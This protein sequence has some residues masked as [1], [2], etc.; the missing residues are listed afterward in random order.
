MTQNSA[1]ADDELLHRPR[2][3]FSEQEVVE[4]TM[5]AAL[6]NMTDRLNETFAT[7]LE[8]PVPGAVPVIHIAHEALLAY[9]GE[10][11]WRSA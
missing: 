2:R 11:A 5:A 7:A 3:E 4:L 1:C 8:T 10:V 9:V 6:W